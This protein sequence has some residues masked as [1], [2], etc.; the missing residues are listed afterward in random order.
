MLLTKVTLEMKL[1]LRLKTKETTHETCTLVDNSSPL[2]VWVNNLDSDIRVHM[3]SGIEQLSKWM[4][5]TR[6]SLLE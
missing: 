5:E 2:G 1:V 4:A 3:Y 6:V